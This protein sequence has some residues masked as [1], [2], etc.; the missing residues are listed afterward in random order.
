MEFSLSGAG[1]LG[2]SFSLEKKHRDWPKVYREGCDWII[3]VG[4]QLTLEGSIYL[5]PAKCRLLSSNL[6]WA[7]L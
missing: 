7:D 6:Q 4:D 2:L 3:G 1:H 5:T